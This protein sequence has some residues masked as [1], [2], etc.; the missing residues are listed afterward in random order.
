[1]NRHNHMPT[2]LAI[3]TALAILWGCLG[4]LVTR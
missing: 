3:T 1:M 4:E 2:L